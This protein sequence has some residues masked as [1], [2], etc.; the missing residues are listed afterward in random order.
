MNM[1]LQGLSGFLF[2]E[3]K[4]KGKYHYWSGQDTACRLWSTGGIKQDRA[5]WTV[6]DKPPARELCHMCKEGQSAKPHGGIP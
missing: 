3:I 6:T 1:R 2:N 4:P 5:G